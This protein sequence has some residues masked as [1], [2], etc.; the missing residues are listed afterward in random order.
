M[1]A[2]NQMRKNTVNSKFFINR[3][4]KIHSFKK[5]TGP[6]RPSKKCLQ[7]CF[8]EKKNYKIKKYG[9]LIAITPNQNISI[10]GGYPLSISFSSN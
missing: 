2:T 10:Y 3:F 5:H 9:P 6:I 7:C 4:N 1:K 8:Y